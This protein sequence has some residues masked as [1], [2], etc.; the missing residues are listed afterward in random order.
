[1]EQIELPKVGD[2]LFFPATL[3]VALVT[4]V[5]GYIRWK[6]LYTD[7]HYS[8]YQCWSCEMIEMLKNEIC[9]SIKKS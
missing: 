2:K 5:Q 9:I 4:D 7:E 6:T 1:M 3:E 8:I